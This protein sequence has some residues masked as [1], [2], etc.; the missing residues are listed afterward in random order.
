MEADFKRIP[1]IV[2]KVKQMRGSAK[3]TAPVEQKPPE[4]PP[5]QMKL[6]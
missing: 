5:K 1:E 3:P 2:E 6:F 4:E